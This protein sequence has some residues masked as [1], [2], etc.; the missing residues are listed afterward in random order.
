MNDNPT[1]E[2]EIAE[3]LEKV[4]EAC[5]RVKRVSTHLRNREK[6]PG[7]CRLMELRA[8]E[9]DLILLTTKLH[10]AIEFFDKSC[11]RGPI[12]SRPQ[13]L[14]ALRYPDGALGP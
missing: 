7:Y 8:S 10:K 2:K 11:L 13:C 14:A 6:V 12:T 1:F 9:Q 3:A 4:E 5:E